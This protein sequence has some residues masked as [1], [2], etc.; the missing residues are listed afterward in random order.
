MGLK[1]TVSQG[2]GV[3]LSCDGESVRVE[4]IEVNARRNR[5]RFAALDESGAVRAVTESRQS[6]HM[7]IRLGEH[8]AHVSARIT[9]RSEGAV[10]SM[11][12]DAPREVLILRDGVG[13]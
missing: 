5:M 6:P 8:V 11:H 10:S 3:T 1:L 2:E 12:F 9:Y 13:E 7:A 4:M